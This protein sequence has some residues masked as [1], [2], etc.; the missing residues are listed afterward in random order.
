MCD[1][2]TIAT[3]ATLISAAASGAKMIGDVA[4][5]QQ[6]KQAAARQENLLMHTMADQQSALN[7]QQVQVNEQNAQQMS[8]RAKQALIERGHMIAAGADTGVEGSSQAR[9]LN[10]STMAE[11][12]DM[13]T[14]EQ[15]R[16]AAEAQNTLNKRGIV[17]RTQSGLNQVVQPSLVGTGL[18]LIGDGADAYSAMYKPTSPTSSTG[19]GMGNRSA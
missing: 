1:P 3:T 8:E 16:N 18:K 11:A 14:L 5:Y 4:Q 12:Q 7:V 9:L 15:N 2:V 6:Q 13:A 17:N 10:A 19:Y